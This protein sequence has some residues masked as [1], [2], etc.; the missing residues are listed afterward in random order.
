MQL[1]IMYFGGQFLFSQE[2]CEGRIFIHLFVSKFVCVI[3]CAPPPKKV[4]GPTVN[5]STFFLSVSPAMTLSIKN[6]NNKKS[7]AYDYM[8][9]I[10]VYKDFFTCLPFLFLLSFCSCSR[11]I[12]PTFLK[13]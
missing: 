11:P 5:K 12:L 10:S 8:H 9:Y 6:K 2:I 4:P 13:S 7:I 3:G 1:V